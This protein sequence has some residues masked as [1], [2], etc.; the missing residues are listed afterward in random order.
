VSELFGQETPNI[1]YLFL[2]I[3][4]AKHIKFASKQ[5]K[6]EQV[7]RPSMLAPF[8]YANPSVAERLHHGVTRP[9]G[10]RLAELADRVRQMEQVVDG[11]KGSN[12]LLDSKTKL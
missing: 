6:L 7:Q 4:N 8:I 2:L 11:N 5:A 12:G 9:E 1:P 3:F 10:K